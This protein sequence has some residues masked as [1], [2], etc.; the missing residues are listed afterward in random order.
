[1]ANSTV[2][3]EMQMQLAIDACHAVDKPNFSA[4]ARQFPPVNRTTLRRRFLGL[5]ESRAQANSTHRQ[6]LTAEQEEQLIQHINMLT[7]HGLPPTS[8]IV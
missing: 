6:N 5:Q 2:N 8:Q 7:D 3:T 1:M 4:I